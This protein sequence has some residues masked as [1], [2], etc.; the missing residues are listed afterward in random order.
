VQAQGNPMGK[1]L[2]LAG[3][4]WLVI[5][6]FRGKKDRYLVSQRTSVRKLK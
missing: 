3:I 1:F 5:A 2:V 6:Y 4:V